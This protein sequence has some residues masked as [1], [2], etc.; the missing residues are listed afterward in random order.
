[1]LD[2]NFLDLILQLQWQGGCQ[3]ITFP[4]I[5]PLASCSS[6]AMLFTYISVCRSS[7]S[8]RK[9]VSKVV[10]RDWSSANRRRRLSTG[11]SE[12]GNIQSERIPYLLQSHLPCRFTP[13]AAQASCWCL[14]VNKGTE[15]A[16]TAMIHDI[17]SWILSLWVSFSITE[18]ALSGDCFKGT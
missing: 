11:T 13:G 6:A 17:P 16:R 12:V 1:M 2:K 14:H 3:Q 10:L 7:T 9:N 5:W 4:R 18:F 15:D 8:G